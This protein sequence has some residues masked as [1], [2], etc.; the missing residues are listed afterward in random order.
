[1]WLFPFGFVEFGHHSVSGAVVKKE[2]FES[3]S[4][5]RDGKGADVLN[6]IRDGKDRH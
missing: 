2:S 1:M 6:Q 4:K 3:D 5:V